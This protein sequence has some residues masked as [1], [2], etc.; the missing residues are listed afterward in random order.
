[1]IMV[2]LENKNDIPFQPKND[3]YQ[4]IHNDKP[5]ISNQLVP[6]RYE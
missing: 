2:S 3:S 1:M 4:G 6:F 5:G